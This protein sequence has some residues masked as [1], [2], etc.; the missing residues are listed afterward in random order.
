MKNFAEYTSE[1]F[2]TEPLFIRWVQ[3]PHDDEIGNFWA[4]WL[5][6]HPS[7]SE[8][9]NEAKAMVAEISTK[10]TPLST[11]ETYNLWWKIKKSIYHLPKTETE[12]ILPQPS[13]G[14]LWAALIVFVF[15]I[16]GYLLF[17]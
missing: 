17:S 2:A 11:A 8:E 12:A 15:L 14:Y 1:D 16:F 10:Y 13:E 9:I 3:Q 4:T 5:T 6:K 7:K